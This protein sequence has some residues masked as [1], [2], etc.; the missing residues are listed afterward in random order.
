MTLIMT[1]ELIL[2]AA[3]RP[4]QSTGRFTVR[5][6]LR[7]GLLAVALLC[8]QAV[9]GHGEAGDPAFI[10]RCVPAMYKA[11]MVVSTSSSA[12]AGNAAFQTLYRAL[13]FSEMVGENSTESKGEW[14]R[15]IG[16]GKDA[17][18]AIMGP[19]VD[20]YNDMRRAGLVSADLERR[21]VIRARDVLKR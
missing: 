6:P 19:C 13:A 4:R 14:E 17:N 7:S 16:L 11:A 15:Q 9:S 8:G 12:D 10:A 2:R 3:L 21:A 5:S 18:Y 1:F 20:K